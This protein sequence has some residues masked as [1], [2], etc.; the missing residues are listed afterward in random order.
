MEN[1]FGHQSAQLPAVSPDNQAA[2]PTAPI[3]P[4]APLRLATESPQTEVVQQSIAILM[5]TSLSPYVMAQ[6]FSQLKENYIAK[7]YGITVE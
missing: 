6:R 2:A 4:N 5:D 3:V 7:T 1:Q